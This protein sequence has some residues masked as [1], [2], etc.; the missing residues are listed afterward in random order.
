M[1]GWVRFA[2]LLGVSGDSITLSPAARDKLAELLADH[3]VDDG[4]RVRVEPGGCSGFEYSLEL[5]APGDGDVTV[6]DGRARIHIDPVSLPYLLG[7]RFD[8]EDEFQRAGFVIENPN[9]TG[10]CGC[11]KSFQA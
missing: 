2:T 3:P 11:G 4:L 1:F 8:Y 9:A 10:S 5:G 7:A 6:A